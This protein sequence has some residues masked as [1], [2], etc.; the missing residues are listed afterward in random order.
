M[1]AAVLVDDRCPA[2]RGRRARSG[3]I[4]PAAGLG[5]LRRAVGGDEGPRAARFKAALPALRAAKDSENPKVRVRVA[6]L[7]ETLD[8]GADVD[9]L[10]RPTLIKLDFRDRPLSEIVD[11]LNARHDLGL[12]FQFGPLPHRGM[13]RLRFAA[14]RRPRRPKSGRAG[15]RSKRIGRC[16]SGRSSTGSARPGHLQHDLHPL[17]RFG[18]SKGR[19]LLFAGVGGTS[20]SSDSGPFRVKVVGLHS[21][22]EQNF[23]GAASPGGG[24]SRTPG[25]PRRRRNLVV[26]MAVI[27][28]P[29][30]VVRQV[31][32]PTFVEAVDDRNRSLL[33]PESGMS[34]PTTR[35]GQSPATDL[36]RV[37]RLRALGLAATPRPGWPLDPSAPGIDPGRDRGLRVRPDRHPP[38]RGGRQVGT[39]RRGDRQRPRG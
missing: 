25:S 13:M 12:T 20:I 38:G 24:R 29:G 4:G 32:R 16:R 11:A 5:P 2:R 1:M 39:Q 31:G 18:L 8:R 37:Q 35:R 30:L 17:G 28:E 9:R 21:T 6:A 36:E 10:T 19:F 34:R 26:R 22:F 27:P 7:L 15:S 33:P 14:L 23:A 3:R